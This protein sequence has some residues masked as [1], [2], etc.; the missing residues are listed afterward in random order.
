MPVTQSVLTSV[1]ILWVLSL[2]VLDH[3]SRIPVARFGVLIC[4]LTFFLSRRKF[5]MPSSIREI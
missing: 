4:N 3:F 5:M 1:E 2:F